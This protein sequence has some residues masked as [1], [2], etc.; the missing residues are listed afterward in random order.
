MT[1][2]DFFDKIASHRNWCENLAE[3]NGDFNIK[4]GQAKVSS[5]Y[6][7]DLFALYLAKRINRKDLQFLVDKT[8]SLRFSKNGKA[9]TFK[10]DTSI[11]NSENTLTNYYDLKTNLGWNRDIEKYIYHKNEFINKIKGRTGWIHFSKKEIQSITFSNDLKY[12]M[13]VVHGW[14]ISQEQLN[15]NIEL[16]KNFENIEFYILYDHYNNRINT[17]DFDRLYDFKSELK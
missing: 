16:V 7:E 4:R 14:N 17:E 13:V 6:I 15:K 11:I 1:E 8:T 2:Q 3:G 9:T 10:P 5:G 12:K